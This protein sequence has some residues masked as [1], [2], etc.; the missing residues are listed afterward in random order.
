VPRDLPDAPEVR[1]DI[2]DYYA[3]V[4]QFD[5]EL[6]EV[7]AALD[8]S[9]RAANTLLIVTSDN[10]W[11]F[12]RGK[13]NLYDGGTRVPLA[14]RWPG[15]IP[16]GGLVGAFVSHRD[17]APT[18]LDAAALRPPPDQDGHSLLFL[19]A[20]QKAPAA[21]SVLFEREQPADGRA[22]EP[23]Y[24]ARAI[25]TGKYL[26]IRNLRPGRWPAGDPEPHAGVGPFGDCD[27][28]PSKQ[29]ILDH[30]DGAT[31][32]F[33]ELAFAR[34]P[35]EELYDLAKDPAQLVNVAEWPDYAGV[36][37]ALRRRLDR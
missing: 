19:A 37:Q 15:R 28:G 4:Q 31:R 12:P 18:I 29:Y 13:A 30:C 20:G 34:R 24:A 33:F 22:G 35:A 17:L 16:R 26:Y 32:R 11:P 5:R 3:E 23:G 25:R 21:E 6:G 27:D 8:A 7:L 36:K 10:G 1:G 14:F 9:G 2:L